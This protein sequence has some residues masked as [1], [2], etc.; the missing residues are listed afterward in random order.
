MGCD[1]GLPAL[2]HTFYCYV[3]GDFLPKPAYNGLAFRRSTCVTCTMTQIREIQTSLGRSGSV[4]NA[5]PFWHGL[6]IMPNGV[7]SLAA[8]AL[9]SVILGDAFVSLPSLPGAGEDQKPL[10]QR[11]W[12]PIKGMIMYQAG[13]YGTAV[14]NMPRARITRVSRWYGRSAVGCDVI[15]KRMCAFCR[16]L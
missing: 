10:K 5:S 16:E 1:L 9:G 11:E 12:F 3:F 15:I 2:T 8:I 6:L 13:N 7:R 4:Q 14:K